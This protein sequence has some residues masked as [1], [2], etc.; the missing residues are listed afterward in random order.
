MRE[1]GRKNEMGHGNESSHDLRV[2][3]SFTIRY[4]DTL[5]ALMIS[6]KCEQDASDC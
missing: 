6:Q 4:I 1:V 2:A 3:L 5:T